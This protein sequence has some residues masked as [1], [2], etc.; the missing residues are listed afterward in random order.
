MPVMTKVCIPDKRNANATG[1]S[2]LGMNACMMG[3]LVSQLSVS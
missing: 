1:S 3:S 2:L